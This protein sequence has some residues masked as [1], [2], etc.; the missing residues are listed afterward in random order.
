MDSVGAVS[1][2]PATAAALPR[3]RSLRVVESAEP[4]CVWVRRM[5]SA[6]D[7]YL[8]LGCDVHRVDDGWAQLRHASTRFV[9]AHGTDPARYLRVA[10]A[11]AHHP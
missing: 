2:E 6:L 10:G 5:S 9:L 1:E 7:F 4:P 3:M 8:A 11:G